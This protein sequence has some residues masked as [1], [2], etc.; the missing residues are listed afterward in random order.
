M[1][2]P[3]YSNPYLSLAI[4]LMAFLGCYIVQHDNFGSQ[5]SQ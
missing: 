3:S 2:F 4:Q 1:L 5:A